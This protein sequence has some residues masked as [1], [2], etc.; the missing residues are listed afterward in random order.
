LASR[1]ERHEPPRRVDEEIREG[2]DRDV[3]A[4]LRVA[5]RAISPMPP[6][7]I[8]ATM[9][10]APRCVPGARAIGGWAAIVAGRASL[11]TTITEDLLANSC[12]LGLDAQINYD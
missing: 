9:S 7:P 8:S 3:A 5:G 6:V 2:F 11:R 10:E 4:E 12:G 1:F